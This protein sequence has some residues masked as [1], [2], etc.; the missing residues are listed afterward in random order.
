MS[1]I[2]SAFNTATKQK[3]WA[4]SMVHICKNDVPSRGK[5]RDERQHSI[6]FEAELKKAKMMSA[7]QLSEVLCLPA[8]FVQIKFHDL[9]KRGLAIR[10]TLKKHSFFSHVDNEHIR[11]V[12]DKVDSVISKG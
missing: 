7:K 10:T 5:E 2:L 6:D 3:K 4:A 9:E 8:W 12:A 1:P 11:K